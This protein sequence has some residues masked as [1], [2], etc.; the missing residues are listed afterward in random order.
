MTENKGKH[1]TGADIN[2]V[3]VLTI[4]LIPIVLIFAVFFLAVDIIRAV[5]HYA[6][7]KKANAN[8]EYSS[9]FS[10]EHK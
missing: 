10:D 4:G 3:R 5:I 7:N 2:W 6:V 9:V 8:K 1:D